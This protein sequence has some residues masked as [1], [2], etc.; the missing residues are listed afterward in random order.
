MTE[1][2]SPF[3]QFFDT[4]GAPLANG[5]I[6]I[7]TANLDAQSN[8][9]PVYW[10]EALTIPALQPIRTLNG[11]PAR[12][13]TPAR[14]FCNADNFSMT[15]KTNTGRTVWSVQD[16]T[17]VNIPSISGPDGSSLVGFVANEAG[18]DPRTVE[19]RLREVL[20][21]RD[22]GAVGDGVT[23]DT[24][25][26]DAFIAAVLATGKTGYLGAGHFVY[27]GSQLL[28][29]VG[30][31][32]A[33]QGGKIVGAG[34]ARTI[35]D[36]SSCAS[37]PQFLFRSASGFLFGW[38]L[39]GFEIRGI[40]N[41]VMAQL[42][43]DWNGSAYG[44]ALNS[45]CFNDLVFRNNST[46]ANAV[47]VRCNAV[48]QSYVK[49]VANNG[50]NAG[51]TGTAVELHG[52]QFSSGL[53]AAGNAGVG[54]A[55]RY[56]TYGNRLNVDCE[57]VQNAFL[58]D[59]LSG[60][61]AFEGTAVWGAPNANPA[62]SGNDGTTTAIIATQSG[63]LNFFN[64]NLNWSYTPTITGAASANIIIQQQG[65]G[66]ERFGG[67]DIR[68]QQSSV[69]ANLYLSAPATGSALVLWNRQGSPD[70]LR[71]TLNMGGGNTWQLDRYNSSS[72]YQ[73][74]PF[75]VDSITG[76]FAMN[77][78]VAVNPLRLQS[79]TVAT[80]PAP[81]LW[82]TCIA[83]VSDGTSNKRLAVSDGTNWR[84]PDGAIVS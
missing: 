1:I 42:G 65:F 44:D 48:L 15:V 34:F 32:A 66:T 33:T 50:N 61:N 55:V 60:R 51:L 83:Y 5:Q 21:L 27:Q 73:D 30:G 75:Y 16:A 53:I 23:N 49:W 11:Y 84:W 62:I 26:I 67:V 46:G 12:N 13:G 79:Y 28:I 37:T 70:Q 39:D 8:P 17:S 69:S 56:Y 41:G 74:T 68:P 82:A 7:G 2:V 63:G 52:L 45:C 77:K 38:T 76:Q 6:Y 78:P 9:I 25:A 35:L 54:I 22:F 40:N 29:T 59:T 14:I 19:S 31:L 47:A 71:W 20:Y 72:V 4:S 57:V 64:E 80:L 81:A 36:V 10:D 3:Q 43:Q 18:A 24:I 58:F